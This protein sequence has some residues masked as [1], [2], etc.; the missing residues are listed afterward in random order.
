M[1]MCYIMHCQ[2]HVMCMCVAFCYANFRSTFYHA[3]QKKL[4]RGTATLEMG[5][6]IAILFSHAFQTIATLFYYCK[7]AFVSATMLLFF[8]AQFVN[9]K[10]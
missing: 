1:E 2:V 6:Q 4:T 9:D 7:L 8:H 10:K 3:E 5:S